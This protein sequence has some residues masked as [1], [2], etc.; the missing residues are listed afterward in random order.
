METSRG[1]KPALL[2]GYTVV[3]KHRFLLSLSD[4]FNFVE[5]VPKVHGMGGI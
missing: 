1:I 5:N 4:L 3:P 2:L